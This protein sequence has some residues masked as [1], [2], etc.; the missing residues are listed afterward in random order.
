MYRDYLSRREP[1]VFLKR[2]W[3]RGAVEILGSS[4]HHLY[5]YF[6]PDKK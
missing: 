1:H 6:T 4:G 2:Y 5:F 3:I